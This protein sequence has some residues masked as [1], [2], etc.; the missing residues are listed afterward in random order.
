MDRFLALMPDLMTGKTV[1]SGHFAPIEVP[2]QVNPMLAR[3]VRLAAGEG[4][5]TAAIADGRRLG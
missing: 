3:F 1:G 5:V 4:A 2:E